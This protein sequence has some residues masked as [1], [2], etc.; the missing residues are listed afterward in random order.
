MQE[1]MPWWVED[2]SLTFTSETAFVDTGW[3][4][5]ENDRWSIPVAL[6]YTPAAHVFYVVERLVE[7][8]WVELK[9]EHYAM[10]MAENAAKRRAYADRVPHRVRMV[11]VDE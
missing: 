4:K 1:E 6:Y 3:R 2:S 9:G 8:G 7:G 5:D 10:A 11:V